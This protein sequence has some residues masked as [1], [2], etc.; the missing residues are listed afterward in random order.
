M[1]SQDGVG[2][3]RLLGA[4]TYTGLT[5]INAGKL[6]IGDSSTATS[7]SNPKA[8]IDPASSVSVGL[9]GVLELAN[10]RS[11]NAATGDN[12]FPNYVTGAGDVRVRYFTGTVLSFGKTGSA[13]N[14]TGAT[15]VDSGTL[16]PLSYDA[17]SRSA[18]FHVASGA[19]L[20]LT[21]LAATGGSFTQTND[22]VLGGSGIVKTTAGSTL[23]L[24]G[25][26][27][28]GGNTPYDV[29]QIGELTLGQTG[30][31]SNVALQVPSSS[32]ADGF[33][34]YLDVGSILS[35]KLTVRGGN[36][37]VAGT[38]F[39]QNNANR[40]NQGSAGSGSFVIVSAP[41]GL[42]T[43]GVNPIMDANQNPVT[44]F[45]LDTSLLPGYRAWL[46]YAVDGKSVVLNLSQVL[47][48]GAVG[49]L[50][51]SSNFDFGSVHVNDVARKFVP[52]QNTATGPSP[53]TL[54]ISFAPPQP[55]LQ[56]TGS[57]TGLKTT[58]GVNN[59]S[60]QLRLS[61][62]TP[63]LKTSSVQMLVTSVSS[64]AGQDP[65]VFAPAVLNATGKV[66]AYA[67]P[68]VDATTLDIGSSHPNVA[69]VPK[70]ITIQNNAPAGGYGES[71]QVQVGAGTS[72]NLNANGVILSLAA[73]ATD[74][75][76]LSAAFKAQGTAGLVNGSFTLDYVSLNQPNSGLFPTALPSQIYNVVGRVY[77]YAVPDA[78]SLPAAISLGS[79]H[80]ND[81]AM[82]AVTVANTASAV[83]GYSE[84][85]SATVTTTGSV[86]SSG[87]VDSLAPQ[88]TSNAI[89]VGVNTSAPGALSGKAN[90]SY[91]SVA[92]ANSGLQ[93]TPLTSL[94]KSINVSA[95]VYDYA[96]PVVPTTIDVGSVHVGEAFSY[97][98][99][100]VQNQ[101]QPYAAANSNY[102]EKL[103]VT[104]P[105]GSTAN[106]GTTGSVV[107]LAAGD[108][109][110]NSLMVTLNTATSSIGSTTGL[111]TLGFNSK[112]IVGSNLSD[113]VLSTKNIT[114]TGRV[115]ALAQV[116]LAGGATPV[117]NL[118]S[119]HSG[120]SISAGFLAVGNS[121]PASLYT[122]T[123]KVAF[124][125]VTAPNNLK[126]SG[127][128]TGLQAGNTDSGT[129]Q[130]G[131]LPGSVGSQVGSVNLLFTSQA[132]PGSGIVGDTSLG[133]ATL[134]VR[135]TVYD[136]AKASVPTTTFVLPA[137]HVGGSF[138]VA[139]IS[140]SNIATASANT[141][142]LNAYLVSPSAGVLIA[143]GASG[144]I[145][146]AGQD[147]DNTTLGIGLDSSLAT[148][149]GL[150]TGS[151][152][153][154]LVSK[155]VAG[156]VGLTDTVLANQAVTISAA[157]YDY[158]AHN[159]PATNT[160]N[161]GPV[162]GGVTYSVPELAVTNTGATGAYTE[163]LKV[164][165][166]NPSQELVTVGSI[167]GLAAG[168]QD[169][170]TMKVG[171]VSG[172]LGQQTG[173]FNL[174]A[175]S[176]GQ[177][178]LADTQ[179]PSAAYSVTGTVYQV[180]SAS[181]L[182]T[183]IYLGAFHVGDDAL[184][185]LTIENTASS[186]AYGEGLTVDANLAV[187]SSNARI[188]G[189]VSNLAPGAT[190]TSSMLVGLDTALPGQITGT[191]SLT[192]TSIPKVVPLQ[193][194]SLGNAS[195][196]VSADVYSYAIPAAAN[197]T[198]PSIHVGDPAGFVDGSISVRNNAPG[199]L[200]SESLKATILN[201]SSNLTARSSQVI[202]SANSNQ[203]LTVNMA[204]PTQGGQSYGTVTLGYTSLSVH[205]GVLGDTPLAT[206]SV[207]EVR[208][209]AYDYARGQV[210]MLSANLGNSLSL[211]PDGHIVFNIGDTRVG[212]T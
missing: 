28:P 74:S 71:L 160:I 111:L 128:V 3:L 202:V 129:M 13:N 31:A 34:Y 64:V 154:R 170:T 7:V 19:I 188:Y 113:T 9:Q 33:R 59:T 174:R 32:M 68:Q 86:R 20:D 164:V 5:L 29:G 159:L 204:T 197:I 39:L 12:L 176:V 149:K 168:A 171:F 56:A 96:H 135:G 85:L 72:S 145:T 211:A 79:F 136:Y 94:G 1:L 200:Y 110:G 153:L 93:D 81:V 70:K 101:L 183:A 112:A 142:A 169:T 143:N 103:D 65:Y 92:F 127:M 173:S 52:V 162:R 185:N 187:K 179:L 10:V 139:P 37:S 43:K 50:T 121:A 193:P 132:L 100:N 194:L 24:K 69:F 102:V 17:V 117:L 62:L 77:D 203:G 84:S 191:V 148:T 180:A 175:T 87:S 104:L 140:V 108:S 25:A 58:D 23:I 137:V 131:F 119:V 18:G 36:V 156:A 78:L 192:L 82:Q 122:E 48:R 105:A 95:T 190:N 152:N 98:A 147:T 30:V 4:N 118:G 198:L 66:Y 63:R 26:L 120:D 151:A 205:T 40:N 80:V 21:S 75:T 99:V 8:W 195:I 89:R 212:G 55:G 116:S 163:P 73:Q 53:D 49:A 60:L 61:T 196:S 155:V 27:S 157:V 114:I 161:L 158:A 11:G 67:D 184:R 208:G 76:S 91:T 46:T 115:Y 88:A 133:Q 106:V 38:L 42:I 107:G 54:D 15:Y 6:I 44:G 124:D 45:V 182:P 97:R 210:A 35:D 41:D 181:R 16:K 189:N 207:V 47:E 134:T 126:L 2:A 51:V 201:T 109:S 167:A 172:L 146:L 165:F 178:G 166:G 138:G 144:S 150:K 177:A 57:I 206:Q 209:N 199:G 186:Q 123:L 83:S 130:V 22:K 141:E 14:Y 125:S 90:I